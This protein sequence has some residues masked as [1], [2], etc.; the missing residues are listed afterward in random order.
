MSPRPPLAKSDKLQ[1]VGETQDINELLKKIYK[2]DDNQRRQLFAILKELETKGDLSG[3][4]LN[5][6]LQ[7]FLN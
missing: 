6:G 3:A 5:E 1:E 7:K 4:K 2:L